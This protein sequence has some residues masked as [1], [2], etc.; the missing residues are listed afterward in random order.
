MYFIDNGSTDGTSRIVER[1]SAKAMLSIEQ[2]SSQGEG[3]S[4]TAF[5]GNAYFGA[6]EILARQLDADWFVHHDA[7]EFRESPWQALNLRDAIQN[8]DRFG[9]NAIDFEVLTFSPTQGTL[10]TRRRCARHFDFMSRH[11]RSIRC[12]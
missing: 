6:K 11:S 9:Y 7:D 3:T 10:S 12:Q 2:F 1:A 5:L 8:V 4:Q